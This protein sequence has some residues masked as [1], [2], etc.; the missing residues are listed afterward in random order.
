MDGSDLENKGTRR[1][2]TRPDQTGRDKSLKIR[3]ERARQMFS[4]AKDSGLAR[5]EDYHGG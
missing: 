3:S 2:E 4:K 5:E 1:D